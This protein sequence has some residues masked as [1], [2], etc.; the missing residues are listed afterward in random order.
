M[1]VA[2]DTVVYAEGDIVMASHPT[3]HPA[4]ARMRVE[5]DFYKSGS[6]VTGT[7]LDTGKTSQPHRNHVRPITDPA[8]MNLVQLY[9]AH[10]GVLVQMST[11]GVGPAEF[12]VAMAVHERLA[13]LIRLVTGADPA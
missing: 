3:N 10:D 9:R 12:D 5:K 2:E 13:E 6:Y 11:G 4:W 1:A 7:F 8:Q